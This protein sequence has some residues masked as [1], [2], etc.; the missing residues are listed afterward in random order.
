MKLFYGNKLEPTGCRI[1]PDKTG[2]LYVML[3]FL[4]IKLCQRVGLEA[5]PGPGRPVF[6]LTKNQRL[7]RQDCF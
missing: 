5:R 6:Y 3:S 7:F 4:L 2:Q 1:H